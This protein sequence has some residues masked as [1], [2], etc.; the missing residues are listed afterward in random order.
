[1][2]ES[3]SLC[4]LQTCLLCRLSLNEWIPA[5][6][7]NRKNL[8]FNRGEIIFSEGSVVTGIYFVYSGTVKVH[9]RWDNDKD[10]IVRFARKGDIVGHRGLGKDNMYPVSATAIES[11]EVCFVDINFFLSSLKVNHDFLFQLMMF[12]AAELKE[13]ERN[14]RNLAH[15]NVKGRIAQALLTL[16][17]KFGTDDEGYINIILSRQDLASYAGTSYETFFRLIN[18]FVEENAIS[19]SGKKIAIPDPQMLRK[20]NGLF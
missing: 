15:M 16:Q 9:K 3:K 2:K 12:Y 13:S 18:E 10:L 5:I 11:T 6:S 4:N 7:A 19:I 20:M 17:E 14:M 8:K 1:M